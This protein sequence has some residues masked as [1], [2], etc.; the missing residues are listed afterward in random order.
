MHGLMVYDVKHT[1]AVKLSRS[2]ASWWFTAL[3][4]NKT[5]L[6]HVLLKEKLLSEIYSSTPIPYTALSFI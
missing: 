2:I 4:A 3:L 1:R 6:C 5:F